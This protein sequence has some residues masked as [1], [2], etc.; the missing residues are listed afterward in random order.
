M[1][2]SVTMNSAQL[3]YLSISKLFGRVGLPRSASFFR[4]LVLLLP[5]LPMH[6]MA[7]RRQ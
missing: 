3:G 6:S 4:K 1:K 7:A 5:V 2:D